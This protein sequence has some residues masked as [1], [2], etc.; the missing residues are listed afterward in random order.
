MKQKDFYDLRRKPK[1]S[2]GPADLVV[3]RL[4]TTNRGVAKKLQPRFT[5]LVEVRRSR[6]RGFS[7]ESARLRVGDFKALSSKLKNGAYH[8]QQETTMT[9]GQTRKRQGKVHTVIKW[10]FFKTLFFLFPI[11]FQPWDV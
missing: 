11:L 1:I 5:G 4:K 8:Q 9:A 3:M 10:K 6:S 2:L 7:K